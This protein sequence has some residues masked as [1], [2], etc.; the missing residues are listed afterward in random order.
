ML[1][2]TVRFGGHGGD[3][4][5]GYL[6]RPIIAEPTPGVVVIHHA[7]GLDP[8]CREVAR[9]L[10]FAGYTTVVPHLYHRRGPGDWADVAA[11][12]RVEGLDKA[13]PNDQVMG[14]VAGAAAYLRTLTNSNGKVGVIGFCSGGRQALLAACDVPTLDAAVNCWGGSIF[15]EVDPYDPEGRRA[16]GVIHRVKDMTV[17]LLGIF[18]NDDLNPSVEQVDRLDKVLTVLDKEHTFHRYDDAG[19]AFFVTDK[20]SYR[21]EQSVDGWKRIRV[22]FQ[23]KLY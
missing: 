4:I 13:M 16:S 12:A 6:A 20:P 19:H 7:P 1:V 5:E 10:A 11:A 18:G 9:N 2:E 23:D 15:P 17:P 8:W 21:Q 3:L 14:D 22:F